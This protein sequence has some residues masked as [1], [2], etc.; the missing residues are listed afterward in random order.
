VYRAHSADDNRE[1]AVK[2][3]KI[4]LTPE[5]ARELAAGLARLCE[6][7]PAH[8][9]LAAYVGAGVTGSTAWLAQEYVPADALDARLRRRTGGGLKHSLPVLRQIAAAVDAAADR[10]LHHGALH[11]R[12]V[13]ISTTGEVK[14][15]GFGVA[16]AL[17]AVGGPPVTRRPYAAPERSG[18]TQR[19]ADAAADVFSLGTIAV[20]MLTGRRPI[21][22][23]AT[24]VGFVSG[25][26]EGIDADACRRALARALADSP[27]ERFATATAF[28]AALARAAE[29]GAAETVRREESASPRTALR[30]A[31]AVRHDAPVVPPEAAP[32]TP[33]ETRQEET[34]A[35]SSAQTAAVAALPPDRPATPEASP[36]PPMRRPREPR[37][38]DTEPRPPERREP[39]AHKLQPRAPEAHEAPAVPDAAPPRAPREPQRTPPPVEIDI[40]AVSHT[41]VDVPSSSLEVDFPVSE[42]EIATPATAGAPPAVAP[43]P[44]FDAVVSRSDS[45]A[46]E[47]AMPPAA[48]GPFEHRQRA[49]WPS[50]ALL[51]LGVGLGL[52]AGYLLWGRD[53]GARQAP[54]TPVSTAATTAP[55][56]PRGPAAA[57]GAASPKE[58]ASVAPEPARTASAPSASAAPSKP[59]A[60]PV[61]GR[62]FVRSRPPGAKV[63]VNGRPRGETPVTIDDLPLGTHELTLVRA[64]YQPST[65]RVSVTTSRT[66]R[67]TVPLQRRPAE[68][69]A[70]ARSEAKPQ[71]SGAAT[72]ATGEPTLEVV[73]RPGGAHVFIDGA[74]AGTTPLTATSLAAGPHAVRLE[75]SG[76]RPWSTNVTL[77]RG[78]RTRVAASLELVP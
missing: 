9:H 75:L 70:R 77:D 58:P 64:G 76:H 62:V 17:A 59:A 36:H 11:P 47:P 18:T 73:S 57:P 60:T 52:L 29:A 55:V 23:G 13:L 78:R 61:R 51:L 22:T 6:R 15:T 28:V 33:P 53:A 43:A 67:V 5:Q 45:D 26:A 74:L 39:V 20:E 10:G 4:D 72:D 12:D 44:Q 37:A 35:E 65:R 25:V 16:E 41:V 19:P 50:A 54:A 7:V 24:A 63:S 8:P 68:P 56:T 40:P 31:P 34:L 49:W 2:L 66:V 21:G 1:V 71:Q 27:R 69:A 38:R 46:H 14:V 3:F 48:V 30:D 32:A 42:A